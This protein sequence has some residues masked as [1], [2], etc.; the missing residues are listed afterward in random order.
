MLKYTGP[1]NWEG[2]AKTLKK[3]KASRRYKHKQSEQEKAALEDDL[4][5]V[6]SIARIRSP[7]ER[8]RQLKDLA[9]PGLTM[10][11]RVNFPY[12][13]LRNRIEVS[14][15]GFQITLGSKDLVDELFRLLGQIVTLKREGRSESRE[16]QRAKEKISIMLKIGRAHV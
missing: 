1:T 5:E 4:E 3:R 10:L 12:K 14:K 6:S 2:M 16:A 7:R 11:P 13:E 15:Q 9:E 8:S